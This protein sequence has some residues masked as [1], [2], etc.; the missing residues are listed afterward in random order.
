MTAMYPKREE[1]GEGSV[2]LYFMF[3]KTIRLMKH[4]DGNKYLFYVCV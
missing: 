1:G 2:K 3:T 4:E